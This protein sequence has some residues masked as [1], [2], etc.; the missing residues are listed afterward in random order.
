MERRYITEMSWIT[1]LYTCTLWPKLSVWQGSDS[2][3]IP[4]FQLQLWGKGLTTHGKSEQLK[5]QGWRHRSFLFWAIWTC[6]TAF[7][8]TGE[9]FPCS[10]F[11]P[12]QYTQMRSWNEDSSHG[13]LRKLWL[14]FF[15]TVPLCRPLEYLVA[16]TR[17]KTILSHH[18]LL[19]YIFLYK[20]TCWRGS[21]LRKLLAQ[22]VRWLSGLHV[23]GPQKPVEKCRDEENHIHMS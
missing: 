14:Y 8:F 21:I 16:S 17:K 12:T 9:Y 6:F 18:S 10:A 5:E 1:Q 15:Q 4:H 20:L 23:V 3:P 2:N 19:L 11:Q 13:C 22:V 7:N